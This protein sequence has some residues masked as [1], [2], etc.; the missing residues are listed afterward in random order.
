MAAGGRRL[1]MVV[2]HPRKHLGT[3]HA[4]TERTLMDTG[5]GCMCRSPPWSRRL[6]TLYAS[7]DCLYGLPRLG[8]RCNRRNDP[9]RQRKSQHGL[10][11]RATAPKRLSQAPS[12]RHPHAKEASSSSSAGLTLCW[13]FYLSP[14]ICATALLFGGTERG[15]E[16][17]EVGLVDRCTE[18]GKV[19]LAHGIAAA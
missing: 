5:A 18:T 17:L 9:L 4:N 13:V 2:R 11:C 10:P 14:R 1:A 3:K 16:C 15:G 6:R 8:A 19:D 7:M 12:L